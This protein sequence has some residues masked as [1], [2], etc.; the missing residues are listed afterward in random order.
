MGIFRRD[1]EDY[2]PTILNGC[3][4]ISQECCRVCYN[5]LEQIRNF[6]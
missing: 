5:T 3:L 6:V 2:L 1:S 4:L